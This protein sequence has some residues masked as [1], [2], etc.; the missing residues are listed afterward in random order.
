MVC[1][2]VLAVNGP[3]QA[4]RAVAPPPALTATPSG[5]LLIA[6]IAGFVALL[7]LG[8]QGRRAVR[9]SRRSGPVGLRRSVAAEVAIGAGVL[10]V[11]AA[12]VNT[13]PAGQD[14]TPPYTATVTAR[15]VE[16]SPI[17]L[18]LDVEPTRVGAQTIH[19][20]TYTAAGA[21]LAFHHAEGRVSAPSRG[22]PPA[23]FTFTDAGPGHGIAQHV[24]VPAPGLW[25]LTVHVDPDATTDYAATTTYT[26]R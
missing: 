14:Y 8:D 15:D 18:V 5:R 4:W 17:T 16:G 20:Y 2:G 25:V 1:V 23:R 9:R 13:V 6:K 7:V 11:T 24:V 26:V 3:F 21:V 10:A 19:L 22:H 12:L